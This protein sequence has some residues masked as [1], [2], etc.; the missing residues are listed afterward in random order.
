MKAKHK[1]ES[2]FSSY[3]LGASI[4]GTGMTIERIQPSMISQDAFCRDLMQIWNGIKNDVS[5]VVF[6]LDE[7]EHLQEIKGAW[8]FL[9]SVFTRVSEQGWRYMLVVSGKLG[10]FRSI[11]GIFSPMERFFTAGHGRTAVGPYL[12]GSLCCAWPQ[13]LSSVQAGHE[14][15]TEVLG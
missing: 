2:F 10:L 11:K 8:G 3:K 13:D 15:K 6:L 12:E 9:R 5:A 7:A 4:L 14:R 1:I